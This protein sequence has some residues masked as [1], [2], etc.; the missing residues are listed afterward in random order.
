MKALLCEAF[1]PPEGLVVRE[2]AAELDPRTEIQA[3]GERLEGRALGAVADDHVPQLR[4]A[5]AQ[6]PHR[7]QH[8]GVALAGDEVGDGDEHRLLHACK[9]Y[10]E[11]DLQG[12]GVEPPDG[13]TPFVQ[14]TIALVRAIRRHAAGCQDAR[15]YPALVFD[16][17]LRQLLG[18]AIQP[19]RNKILHPL[20]ARMLA[21]WAGE[22]ASKLAPDLFPR[23]G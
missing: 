1:G 16:A 21:V 12:D 5:I 3:A 14:N 22:W 6:H 11:A 13:A 19:K 23:R 8:V 20:H 4:P 18:L 7:A 15:L 2:L 17:A 9:G 10:Y